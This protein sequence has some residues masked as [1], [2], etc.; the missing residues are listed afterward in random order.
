MGKLLIFKMDYVLY[1]ICWV[2]GGY[3]LEVFIVLIYFCVIF[4][5]DIDLGVVLGWM[6][7]KWIFYLLFIR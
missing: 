1:F 3:F 5:E 6:I 7:L 4:V 2:M